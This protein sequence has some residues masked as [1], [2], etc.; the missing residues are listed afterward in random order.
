LPANKGQDPQTGE[1]G[2]GHS[3]AHDAA[4]GA[5]ASGAS[6]LTGDPGGR[7]LAK[8]APET[9]VSAL[10]TRQLNCRWLTEEWAGNMQRRQAE[11]L[12]VRQL[13]FGR[14]PDV[15]AAIGGRGIGERR[16][17]VGDRAKIGANSARRAIRFGRLLC[18][19]FLGFSS[20]L[21]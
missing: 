20:R 6:A 19:R 13:H 10:A 5:P 16:R 21:E 2:K 15:V 1:Y 18:L 8:G 9:T 12:L 14:G 4:G 3:G 11:R 17:R 7:P